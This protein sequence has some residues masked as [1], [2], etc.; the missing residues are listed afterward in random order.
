MESITLED[1]RDWK[2]PPFD[3][4]DDNKT[5]VD[6]G[7]I[8]SNVA[9]IQKTLSDFGIEVEMG[10]VNVGPTVTQYTLRPATGVKLSQIAALQNDLALALAAHSI[11]MELPIPG[12][13]LVGIEV[14][15]KS[16]AIVRLRE[17]MQTTDFVKAQAANWFWLWGVMLPA[18]RRLLISPKCLTY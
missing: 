6:S 11:R 15:N 4:L 12:K 14:P 2:L 5:E 10:E 3:L 18:D 13:A 8:E 17:V 7:D 1:R 16:S 9:I